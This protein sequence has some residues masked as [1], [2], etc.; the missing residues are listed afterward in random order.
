MTATPLIR[1]WRRLGATDPVLT[2]TGTVMLVVLG[3]TAVGMVIDPRT[4][5]GAP[6][7]LKPAKFAASTAIYS[8][9][10]AWLLGWL[11][12][13]PRLRRTASRLTAGV[14]VLEVGLISLQAARGVTSHFNGSTPFDRAIYTTMGTAIVVQ[15][16][17]MLPVVW[18]LFRQTFD[19]RSIAWAV[20]LGL[21]ISVVGAFAGGVMTRPTSEQLAAARHTG[22]MAIVGAHTVGAPDGGKGLP[23]TGWSSE[24]GDLRVAHFLGLHAMQ[25]L[26]LIA[27]L[28]I[29]RRRTEDV[30]VRLVSAAA[31][32]YSGL[33]VMLLW[34]ALRGQSLIAPDGTTLLALV[35][36]AAA[37]VTIGSRSARAA[38]VGTRAHA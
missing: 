27:L 2:W 7:W 3:L 21:L 38:L 22:E 31:F 8:F 12:D 32:G 18:A 4:I 23:I 26:P 36:W 35:V 33:F 24:H 25:I 28:P 6:A 30:R 29:V 15:S 20:R 16:M 1:T 13:R 10:L 14:F 5:G 11:T 19:D 17:A 37:T 34:Q 9:T